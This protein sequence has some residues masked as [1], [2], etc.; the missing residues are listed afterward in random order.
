[1]PFAVLQQ[2]T[3]GGVPARSSGFRVLQGKTPQRTSVP[4]AFGVSALEELTSALPLR[5]LPELFRARSAQRQLER[6][7]STA[8]QALTIQGRQREEALAQARQEHPFASGLGTAAG[9]APA[10]FVGGMATA[11]LKGFRVLQGLARGGR[12]AR[13]G[14]EAIRSGAQFGAAEAIQGRP[15]E[16][17]RGVALGAAFAPA[18]L[19]RTLPGRIGLG[20]AG[21]GFTSAALAPKGERVAAGAFG[22]GVGAIGGALTRPLTKPL[23]RATGGIPGGAPESVLIPAERISVSE[24]S[25]AA[26][27]G[28]AM[29]KRPSMRMAEQQ[30]LEAFRARF[31]GLF[32]RSLQENIPKQ[33]LLTGPPQRLALPEPSRII[34]P[35]RGARRPEIAV[36]GLA[37]ELPTARDI[38]RARAVGPQLPSAQEL[39]LKG[40]RVPRTREAGYV[41]IPEETPQIASKGT[42]AFAQS[43]LETRLRSRAD[44][45]A[46]RIN[47]FQQ[48]LGLSERAKIVAPETETIAKTGTINEPVREPFREAGAKPETRTFQF[49]EETIKSNQADLVNLNREI[50]ELNKMIG[51]AGDQSSVNGSLA[52]QRSLREAQILFNRQ[53][54]QFRK[55]RFAAGRAVKTFDVPPDLAA[56]LRE[57]GVLTSGLRTA[58]VRLPIYTNLLKSLRNIT[59]LTQTE[60]Q[61]FLRDLVDAWRL[62]LF[63]VTSWTLDLGGNLTETFA[64]VGGAAGRDIGHALGGRLTFPSLKGFF[65]ALKRSP[66][67]APISEGIEQQVA[68]GELV[69]LGGFGKGPGTFTTRTT[70]ASQALDYL[71]GSPLYA[72]GVVDGGFRKFVASA[73][74]WR[75]AI[76]AADRQ[77]FRG[78]ERR[79]FY[80]RFWANPTQDAIDAVV[81]EGNKAGF[82]RSLSKIEE[83]IAGSTAMRLF[84]DAF[85]RWPFQFTRAMGE[86][87]GV[88]PEMWRR[89]ASGRHVADLGEYLGKTLT[90]WGG[91]WAINELFY[92]NVDWRSM[93]YVAP[94]GNRVRLSGRDPI[95]SI[96]F[97]L[98]TIK[99]DKDAATSALRF[100][101]LPFAKVLVG[102]SEGRVEGGLLGGLVSNVS[103]AIQQRQ[104]LPRGLRRELD[105][106]VN[107]LIPGQSILS[108]L[109]T[110]FDP[111][112]REGIG[113]NLPGVS[114]ALPAAINPTTG[115]P[116]APAQRFL[117]S[118]E[119]PQI[120]GTPIPG[121]E[122]QL[123]PVSRLL[124]TLGLLTYRGPR[125]PIAGVP[126]SQVDES[127]RR[128]WVTE[129]GKQ[130]QQLLLPVARQAGLLRRVESDPV[131]REQQRKRV[132]ALDKIAAQRATVMVQSKRGGKKRIPRQPTERER[133][134]PR[135]FV[136]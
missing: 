62:N 17:P 127:V 79:A 53:V 124:S 80:D 7:D 75:K 103:R 47:G 82:A 122:R 85:A 23:P 16:V 3:A 65:R 19:A 48:R 105:D 73:H 36:E 92:D 4:T 31:P 21:V 88:N 51:V 84:G 113:A 136:R 128:E 1:M 42:R 14:A 126:A 33:K 134:L 93:E 57:A 131:F 129:L 76:E 67:P 81:R 61:A 37:G 102:L 39:A 108:A 9:F 26:Q 30:E 99:G 20:A 46:S 83:R 29:F 35:F 43:A 12:F 77:G 66:L 91:V 107:R 70:P 44:Q 74:L 117:G 58:S 115:A 60:Q 87:L 64:Q 18:G 114:L 59:R 120:G 119:F 38:A 28:F 55:L 8:A 89:L 110:M 24:A 94:E 11:P 63:A 49:S 50:G 104:V 72:K 106:T 27:E 135:R 5:R 56:A 10:L 45:V 6:G 125:S 78:L 68:G 52:A 69:R 15:Q 32:P 97:L 86:W 34:Q 25:Q 54:E 13:A 109:K 101:S 116:L 98:A 40:E 111:I 100:A 130:R 112:T 22:A 118:P 123:D 132:Q 95:P 121:A 133:A 71:V 41:F 96:L 2:R 90:G